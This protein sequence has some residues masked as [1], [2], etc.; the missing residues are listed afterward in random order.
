VPELELLGRCLKEKRSQVLR[1][2]IAEG[3]K[4]KAMT[5]YRQRR[6]SLGLAARIAGMGLSEFLDLLKEHGV[7][8]NLD[9]D[10]AREAVRNAGAM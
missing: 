2:L 9:L 5:L 7:P 10:E 8:L 6:A 3:R 4:M 1:D